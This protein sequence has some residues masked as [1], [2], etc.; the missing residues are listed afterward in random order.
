VEKKVIVPEP[1]PRPFGKCK[2]GAA[3][4]FGSPMCGEC[5]RMKKY[6][7]KPSVPAGVG[8]GPAYD[9]DGKK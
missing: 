3:L 7:I 9:T 6:N 1:A 4:P 8:N 2:C 5:A